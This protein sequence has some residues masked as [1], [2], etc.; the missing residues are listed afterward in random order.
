MSTRKKTWARWF[1]GAVVLG[2]LGAGA[3]PPPTNSAQGT[4]LHGSERFES[5][6]IPLASVESPPPA[7]MKCTTSKAGMVGGRLV[8]AQ[9]CTTGTPPAPVLRFLDGPGLVKTTFRAPFEG[10]SVK[11]VIE[12]ARCHEDITA[13]TS[14][15]TPELL[16]SGAAHWEFRVTASTDDSNAV[17]LCP[18]GSGFA[19]AV[20]HAWSAGGELTPNPDYFTFACAPKNEGTASQPFFVGGGVIAKCIDWGYPP[21]AGAYP[22]ATARDYHQLCTRMAMADYCGEGRSNTLDG[23][24]LV[25]MGVQNALARGTEGHVPTT[26]GREGYA[27]EAVW[28][29]SDCGEVQPLCLGKKRWDSLSMEATCVNRALTPAVRRLPCESLNLSNMGDRTLLV[30]YSLFIDHALVTFQRGE[31]GFVTTTAVSLKMA[32]TAGG[33]DVSGYSVDLDGDGLADEPASFVSL[34]MEGPL[35]S[36]QLPASLQ[37]RMGNFIKPLYRCATSSGRFLLTDSSACDGVPGYYLKALNGDRGIE[38]YLYSAVDSTSAGQRRPLTLW[39]HPTALGY[40]TSTEAPPGFVFV[41]EL[42]YLPAV[43]QLPGRDLESAA[44]MEGK[45]TRAFQ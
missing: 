26:Q 27:L 36:A 9:H 25:F 28:E 22:E 42:G 38:G 39:R 13:P 1:L 5:I 30:S 19:L 15:C 8:V 21:W 12:E 34:R 31:T 17:P 20:P 29:M 7:G 41:R 35:L 10:R 43:G 37:A 33:L 18:L 45:R 2:G 4:R 6:N 24:P 11:L 14:A 23:T 32:Y 3:E 44:V 40:A 16:Q